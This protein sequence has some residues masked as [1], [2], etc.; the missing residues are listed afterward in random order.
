MGPRKGFHLMG[1]FPRLGVELRR[2]RGRLLVRR[3]GCRGRLRIHLGRSRGGLRIYLD[4]GR[5]GGRGGLRIHLGRGRGRLGV[6]LGRGTWVLSFALVGDDW[7][8]AVLVDVI[9]DPHEASVGKLHV[10]AALSVVAV[11][12][13]LVTVVVAG[14]LVVDV[15]LEVVLGGHRRVLGLLNHGRL[16]VV[17]A[18]GSRPRRRHHTQGY[19]CCLIKRRE[20]NKII[21][22]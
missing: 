2:C 5:S 11:A 18:L 12:L 21:G 22:K 6:H 1:L 19:D 14:I 8:E 15:P 10:V 13:F 20:I 4:R 9:L 3:L 16:V 17:A 7:V